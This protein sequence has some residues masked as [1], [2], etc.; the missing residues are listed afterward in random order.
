MSRCFPFPPPGYVRNPAAVAVPVPVADATDKLQKERERADRK[1]EK[2]NEKKALK[3]AGGEPSKHSKRS[4]KK[5]KHEE[6]S[7]AGQ[8]SKT[9]SKELVE[10]LEKSGL[11]EE[12][13]AP[14]FTQTV[15]GSP[16]SSQDSSKRRKVV[17]PSPS[18]NKNGTVFRIKVKGYQGPP[19][20]M[21]DS[22]MVPQQPPVQQTPPGSSLLS[23]Q[24]T[25]QP[26][27]EATAKSAAVHR[28]SIKSDSQGVLK[29][30]D[31]QLP[32][33]VFP[34]G[35]LSKEP[36][37]QKVAPLSTSAK[38]VQKI[39][40][41]LGSS[42]AKV[43]QRVD[44]PPAKVL[45]RADLPPAKV[46][47]RADLPPAK[48]LRGVDPLVSSKQ[49]QR[50]ASSVPHKE[51]GATALHQPDRQQLPEM[52][53]P[54][55]PVVKQQQANSLHKEEPCSS[56]RN[57]EKMAAPEVKLSKS[58][59]KKSRKSEKKERKFGDLFVTW[60]PPSL[61]M[62]DAC[63]LGDQDWLLVGTT[64]PDARIG[65]CAASDGSLPVQSAEQF[66]W[67]PRAIHLPDLD[68]YQL[69]YVVPF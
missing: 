37:V 12:H 7:I 49:L 25:I 11:S 44:L 55:L 40:P 51:I 56:G 45:Q 15:H 69:P 16:E 59:R 47:Q 52:Q 41:R 68:L 43:L 18:Q 39:D 36:S 30:V 63:G 9:A 17:L 23:T 50:D 34:R 21:L 38:I 58:D 33:K 48:V 4:H 29:P 61:E 31:A 20:P 1:K 53:R 28:Q 62:E 66:S 6:V 19:S 3:L 60:N 46:L 24:N 64:K 22:S 57:T 27:R 42:S 8:E 5:R 54:E 26:Q 2:K 13:G 35:N 14:F 67:Q 65:G 32:A 10:Q